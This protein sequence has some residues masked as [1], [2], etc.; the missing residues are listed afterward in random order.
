MKFLLY[1]GFFYF[2]VLALLF[3]FQRNMMY[4]PGS[5]TLPLDGQLRAE[6][7]YA[8]INVK[9]NDGLALNSYY[10][11]PPADSKVIVY[12]QGNGGNLTMRLD[13]SDYF[14]SQGYGFLFAQYRGYAGNPGRPSEK[15]LYE[16]ARAY[17]SWLKER[18]ITE[19]NMVFYG[20]SLGTGIAIQMALEHRPAGIILE[21]AYDSTASVAQ[22]QYWMFPVRLLMK[23]QYRSIEKIADVK[24]PILFIH[25]DKDPLITPDRSARLYERATAP[26]SYHLINGA[27]HSDVYNF[28][29]ALHVFE[30][31]RTLK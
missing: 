25:G 23:D 30:F 4:F 17:I 2:G 24:A 21:A 26:K 3:L 20:E 12:F 29:A 8:F 1:I 18:G 16:D 19:Q 11:P 28:G 15:G 7:E 13:R 27:S 31:L 9:T 5:E 14:I 6:Q 10:A 22:S